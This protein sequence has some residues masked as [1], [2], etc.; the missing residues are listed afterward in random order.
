M[1]DYF[2]RHNYTNDLVCVDI[3]FY[4]Q[5]SATTTTLQWENGL[6]EFAH[7][8]E[9]HITHLHSLGDVAAAAA[10]RRKDGMGVL[11]Y[12]HSTEKLRNN[13]CN[14]LTNGICSPPPAGGAGAGA[15]AGAKLDNPIVV[16]CDFPHE[17]QTVTS[18]L[19]SIKG[20]YL[21]LFTPNE[22]VRG[23][24]LVSVLSMLH[25][26]PPGV[27]VQVNMA[28][29]N[30]LCEGTVTRQ[31]ADAS[32]DIELRGTRLRRVPRSH[33]TLAVLDQAP[34]A[35]EEEY[36]VPRGTK[37]RVSESWTSRLCKG[38]IQ[39]QRADGICMVKVPSY[40]DTVLDCVSWA[41]DQGSA[42]PHELKRGAVGDDVVVPPPW[43]KEHLVHGAILRRNTN[44][45]Y[46]I[47]M[48]FRD[49]PSTTV[50]DQVP[51]TFFKL[52][53][54]VGADSVWQTNMVDLLAEEREV[55][56]SPASLPV[57]LCRRL[58]FVEFCLQKKAQSNPPRAQPAEGHVPTDAT[59]QTTTA[60]PISSGG[61]VHNMDAPR[62]ASAGVPDTARVQPRAGSGAGVPAR[63][64]M[65][66]W[67][68]PC[69]G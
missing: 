68:A 55:T 15:G 67:L 35:L 49:N 32:C 58:S 22:Q 5:S 44:G 69:H 51:R 29:T 41:R 46:A 8:T 61:I 13:W 14:V 66:A 47:N 42:V 18:W 11:I 1:P 38:R 39:H 37:V 9:A 21:L 7:R 43:I 33:F 36:E 53:S 3:L 24:Q 30:Q 26:V 62:K 6:R 59:A 60:D 65:D 4:S 50:L 16:I 28:S 57:R 52:E 12:I 40:G 27:Q 56:F 10:A 45:T 64:D 2:R 34:T 31:H 48:L 54:P 19:A 20:V 23:L 25:V 17:A 63:D